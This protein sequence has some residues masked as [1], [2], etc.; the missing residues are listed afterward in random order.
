MI[1]KPNTAYAAPNGAIGLK[2][3]LKDCPD[4]ENDDLYFVRG[5]IC[6]PIRDEVKDISRGFAICAAQRISTKTIVVFEATRFTHIENLF[7]DNELKWQGLEDWFR[8]VYLKYYCDSF[9]WSG[10]LGTHQQYHLQV[11]RCK[12]MLRQPWMIDIH[13][14]DEQDAINTLY[15][16]RSKDQL[17]IDEESVLMDDLL[18]WEQTGRKH[19]VPAVKALLSLVSGYL[20]F[21]FQ[22]RITKDQD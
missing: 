14:T 16:I 3:S 11:I 2:F 1:P 5:A 4:K 18:M 20:A 8:A 17:V 10:N 22:P 7:E 12:T 13:I 21:P 15:N 9:F 6:W 19:D